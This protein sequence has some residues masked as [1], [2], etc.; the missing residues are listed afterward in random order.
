M[1]EEGAPEAGLG[2]GHEEAE[3]ERAEARQLGERGDDLLE[4][5]DPVAKPR[6]VLEAKVGREPPQLRAERRQRRPGSPPSRR[7]PAGP[8]GARPAPERPVRPGRIGDAPAGATAPQVDVPVGTGA[9]GVR[10]RPQLPE[11]TQLL[12]RRLELGAQ[13]APLDPLERAER[14]LDRRPLPLAAEVRAQAGAQVTGAA[15]VQHLVVAVAEEVDARP[16]RRAR[17]QRPAAGQPPRP[18]RRQLDDVRDRRRPSLLCE[19]EQRE[20]DLGGRLGVGERTVARG[21]RGADE[22]RE[23]GEPDA[24]E[25]AV[26]KAAR[27]PDRVDHGRRDP[28][29]GQPLDLAVEEAE[30]EAGIV[31]DEHGVAGELEEAPDRELGRRRA[32]E[33]ARVDSGQGGDR[34]GQRPPWVDQGLEALRQLERAHADG[35]DLAD[36][37]AA[38][39]R[40][41][42]SPGRRRRRSR[43]R[44]AAPVPGGAA[45]PTLAPR[46]ARRESPVTTSSS[47]ERASPVGTCRS[48]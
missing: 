33:G 12:E 18:R 15:D 47:R 48:A 14:R 35:A 41:P 39:A 10:G 23:R 8:A 3:L 6:R 22:V 36:R 45:R 31:R 24:T 32:R 5:C 29:P 42:S 25:P 21:R 38:R 4:R 44:A 40:D 27:E 1:T 37:G 43:P 46:Q 19:P 20:Q 28:P 16:G 2:R 9:A 11:Q 17:R 7:G 13:H 26:E 34:D 30:V